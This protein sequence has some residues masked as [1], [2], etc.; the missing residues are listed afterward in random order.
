MHARAGASA[1]SP[2][3]RSFASPPP[4]SSAPHPTLLPTL[5][6]SASSPL[7]SAAPIGPPPPPTSHA[8]CPHSSTRTRTTAA[9]SSPPCADAAP[10]RMRCR[11][12]MT[13]RRWCVSPTRPDH[14]A[15]IDALLREGKA[16]EAYV[17][18]AKQMD[19]DGVASGLPE[20]ERMLRAFIAGREFD[21]TEEV[22]DEMLLRGLMPDVGVYNVYV[23]ALC[24]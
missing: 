14:H 15:V 3:R 20:F 1:P 12:W 4:S 24:G 13:C 8:A 18:V 6:R 23:G 17:V 2:P 10:P 5:R 7:R 22:F 16:A 11:S 19:A 9:W 21:A